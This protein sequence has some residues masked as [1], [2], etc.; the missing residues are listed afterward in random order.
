MIVGDGVNLIDARTG[1]RY[2]CPSGANGYG[3]DLGGISMEPDLA[4]RPEGGARHLEATQ[5]KAVF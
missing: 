2:R 1:R 4:G 5:A 3:R